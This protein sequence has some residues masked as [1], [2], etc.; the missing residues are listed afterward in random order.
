M[1]TTPQRKFV[2]TPENIAAA[3]NAVCSKAFRR[4]LAECKTW[5]DWPDK[6]RN[7][8]PKDEIQAFYFRNAAKMAAF[9]SLGRVATPDSLSK[10]TAADLKV[11]AAGAV[12]V[13]PD[14]G[15]VG[16]Y[17]THK[18]MAD[19]LQTKYRS[20]IRFVISPAIFS[21]WHHGR[22]KPSAKTPPPPGKRGNYLI[23]DEYCAWFETHILPHWKHGTDP[24][25][26]LLPDV[27][28]QAQEAEAHTKIL[29]HKIA[30]H[31]WDVEQGKY[32]L[33]EQ[34]VALV[35]GGLNVLR[36]MFRRE[37]ET[38]LPQQLADWLKP[39]LPPDVLLAF[40][41]FHLGLERAAVDR[42]EGECEKFGREGAEQVQT[43]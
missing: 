3:V 42:I 29:H 17:N 38:S 26:A 37:R 24:Q 18:A 5:A 40:Q 35:Y 14:D 30:Q 36:G 7:G 6:T 9:R 27:M 22:S 23:G 11:I 33:K 39:H 15:T 2:R 1:A 41:E 10:T 31:E 19:A 43:A 21:D 8:W 25:G 12:K 16:N 32:I 28:S 4:E 34:A 20:Q 13:Q